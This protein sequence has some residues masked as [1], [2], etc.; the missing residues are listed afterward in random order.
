M[1]S[2]RFIIEGNRIDISRSNPER[3]RWRF[4]LRSCSWGIH[5]FST[6]P[7]T[8]LDQRKTTRPTYKIYCFFY[9]SFITQNVGMSR[10]RERVKG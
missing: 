7:P 4:S 2:E 10:V 9:F 5:H 3:C 8:V 6:S 1:R